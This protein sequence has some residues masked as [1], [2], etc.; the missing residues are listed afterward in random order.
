MGG[1]SYGPGS[2]GPGEPNDEDV[3]EGDFTES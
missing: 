3:I 2:E 1:A